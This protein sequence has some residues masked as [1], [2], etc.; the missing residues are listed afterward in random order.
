LSESGHEITI[1]TSPHRYAKD[2]ER[3]SIDWAEIVSVPSNGQF[4]S[5]R[6]SIEFGINAVKLV[7][8]CHSSKKFDIIHGHSGYT[9]PA[10]ISALSKISTGVPAIHSVYC[11]IYFNNTK[12]VNFLSNSSL[13]RHYFFHLNKIVATSNA[14]KTSLIV[15][16][17]APGRID[18]IPPLIEDRFNPTVNGDKIRR[19]YGICEGQQVFSYMGNL[20]KN[21][22]LDLV[23]RSLGTL[24]KKIPDF[25][26]LMILNMPLSR[27][28]SNMLLD[29]DMHL[30]PEIRQQI[31]DFDL[32]DNIIPIG[33]TEK[34]PE[35]LAAS[36]FFLLPFLSL[37]GVADP[38]LSLVEAMAVGKAVIASDTGGVS[39]LIRNLD[40]GLLIRPGDSG[41]LTNAIE[42]C[43]SNPENV[44]D[45]GLAAGNLVNQVFKK[46]FVLKKFEELYHAE[47]G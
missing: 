43:I 19:E 40:T 23:I 31:R 9:I 13:S 22:G 16:G 35:I 10:A 36:D 41:E 24:K 28:S 34:M 33:L 15:S 11:P 2:N 42:Y 3:S 30:I 7:K 44:K 18:V 20:S 25:K 32:E 46:D 1:I 12:M 8:K 29:A 6:K 45:M 47:A 5:F 37:E 26:L 27:Y 14:V 17:I 38:P 21:K 39:E 4:S